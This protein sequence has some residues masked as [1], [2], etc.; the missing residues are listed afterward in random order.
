MVRVLNPATRRILTLPRAPN[1]VAPPVPTMAF[2]R[3]LGLGHDPRSDTY[4]VVCFF[5]RSMVE[6]TTGICG[7][8]PEMT[9]RTTA[10]CITQVVDIT[11]VKHRSTHIISL[12]VVQ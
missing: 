12:R 5:Y 1:G 11:Q 10:W 4:K 6:L 3:A 2:N 7:F 9:Q 8:L